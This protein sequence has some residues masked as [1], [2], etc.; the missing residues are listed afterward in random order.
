MSDR[1]PRVVGRISTAGPDV[2]TRRAPG[3]TVAVRGLHRTTCSPVPT[4]S[5]PLTARLRAAP[6]YVPD[7][8]VHERVVERR[9]EVIAPALKT[10]APRGVS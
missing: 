4:S 5:S 10:F 6:P 8:L 1:G 2:R 3:V 7:Q 9:R